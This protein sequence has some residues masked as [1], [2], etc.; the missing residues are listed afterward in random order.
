MKYAELLNKINGVP[1]FTTGMLLAGEKDAAAVRM[2]ISRWVS[3]GKLVQLRRSV[4]TLPE[5]YRKTPAHPFLIANALK[6]ASYV[7]MQSALQHYGLIP[8]H[9][10]TVTSVTAGRPETVATSLGDFIFGHVK[11]KWFNGCR[12]TDLG[13]G[14]HAFVATP[15]KGLLDLLYLTPRSDTAAFIEE[16]RLQ[17]VERLNVAILEHHVLQLASVKVAAGVRQFLKVHGIEVRKAA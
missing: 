17:H 3:H 2:Q 14:Q 15:E 1:V 6:A 10:P 12:L 16:L 4:Y 11:P 5:P 13:N 7:S 8:E 9:V